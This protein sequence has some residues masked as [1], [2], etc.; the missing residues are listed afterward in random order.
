MKRPFTNIRVNQQ[1]IETLESQRKARNWKEQSIQALALQTQ[2]SVYV[3]LSFALSDSI[4]HAGQA[5]DHLNSCVNC[6]I[7][8]V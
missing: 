6:A 5:K 3:R 4:L 2:E 8:I 1:K 7:I